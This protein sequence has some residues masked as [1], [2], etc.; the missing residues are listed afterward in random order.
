MKRI[1]SL[2]TLIALLITVILVA[3][4]CEA[5]QASAEMKI[6]SITGAGTRTF[7]MHLYKDGVPKL[8]NPGEDVDKMFTPE[9]GCY[10]PSGAQAVV[11]YIN[12]HE[13]KP[14]LVDEVAID[15]TDNYYDLK[16]TISF[17]SLSDFIAK[18][19][20]LAGGDAEWKF[21]G[22]GDGAV[23]N[24]VDPTITVEDV[25]DGKKI[26]YNEDNRLNSAATKWAANI[27]WNGG[28]NPVNDDDDV[29]FNVDLAKSE[30]VSQATDTYETR[31]FSVEVN[32]T[33]TDSTAAVTIAA[34]GFFMNTEKSDLQALI[35]KADGMK[36]EDFASGWS[37]LEAALAAAK[38]IDAKADATTAEIN[39]AKTALQVAIDALGYTS[40][41]VAAEADKA[42]NK[43]T[44]LKKDEYTSA[45]WDALQKALDDLKALKSQTNVKIAQLNSAIEAVES[46]M[47]GLAKAPATPS[48]GSKPGDDDIPP[49]GSTIPALVIPVA[50]LSAG[51]LISMKKKKTA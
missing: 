27:L 39:A 28:V 44:G 32:G 24:V 11:D 4:S 34:S 35:L 18:C 30:F 13:D 7:H 22:I 20:T 42:I 29:V 3:V 14:D 1:V 50:L 40:A 8:S 36:A 38:D 15:E 33:K 43:T 31:S 16:F 48:E 41:K 49:T 21:K 37:A 9:G 19:K 23:T 12:S 26:T 17:T 5:G 51:L 25:T 46:A 45:S 10:F 6:T 2:L 47:A